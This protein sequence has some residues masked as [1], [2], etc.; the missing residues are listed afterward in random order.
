MDPLSAINSADGSY[1]AVQWVHPL[2]SISTDVYS[3]AVHKSSGYWSQMHGTIHKH[4][5]YICINLYIRIY[6]YSIHDYTV[7]MHMNSFKLMHVIP[8]TGTGVDN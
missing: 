5:Q 8:D 1:T 2:L 7:S 4:M 6:T 3:L